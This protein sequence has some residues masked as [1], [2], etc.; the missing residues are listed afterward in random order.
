M[1]LARTEIEEICREVSQSSFAVLPATLPAE[2]CQQIVEYATQQIASLQGATGNEPH[3]TVYS[4]TRPE[5]PI[6]N[7]FA[8]R[9]GEQPCFRALV[10]DPLLQTLASRYLGCEPVLYSAL[11]WASPVFGGRNLSEAAQMY[12]YDFDG[13]KFLKFFV[14]LSDVESG[15]GPHKLIPGS[16]MNDKRSRTL[17]A[18]DGR[19]TD[20]E[21][22]E[23]YDVQPQ[24]I[25]GKAGT[26]FAEDTFCWHKGEPPTEQDRWV[27]QL[28]YSSF[29]NGDTSAHSFR[30][31][32]VAEDLLAGVDHRTAP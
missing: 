2:K 15:N 6:Y 8:D 3:K 10:A 5:A 14:Y 1:T 24:P 30:E 11:V 18:R 13:T 21:I 9:M 31:T 32:I 4:S 23:L 27:L 12:H 17:R 19:F 22:E 25:T 26:V 28:C 16:H 20:A 7:W 29:L